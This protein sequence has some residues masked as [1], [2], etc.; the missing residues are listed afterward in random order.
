MNTSIKQTAL[1]DEA[2]KRIKESHALDGDTDRLAKYYRRWVDSYELDVE[3][4]HYCGPVIVAELTG[5]LQ[6]AYV[7]RVRAATKILDAG[8]G[9]GL[10]GIELERLGFRS[11]D[12]FDLSEAMVEKARGTGVYRDVRGNVDLN[13]SLVGYPDASYDMTVCCGVFTLGHVRPEGLR[14]L[15][16]VTRPHG[17]VVVSARKSYAE[18]TSFGDEVLRLEEAGVLES[19]QC[20]N[21]GRYLEEEGAHYW[22]LRVAEKPMEPYL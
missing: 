16:R 17:L 11:I 10:V 7:D 19:L 18:A 8:C 13:S 15:A 14:E 2:Q 3:R 22:A 1:E 20:L 5:A 9:T 12:G 4:E 6:T 21:D